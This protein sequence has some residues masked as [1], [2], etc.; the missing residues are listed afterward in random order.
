MTGKWIR[1]LLAAAFVAMPLTAGAQGYQTLD[2]IVAI[3]DEGVILRSELDQTMA[4]VVQQIS[5]RGDRLPPDSVLR[6]QV[7]ERLVMNRVQVQR[8]E[9]T[10]VRVSDQEVDQALTN[11]ANQNR[12]TLVQLRQAIEGDGMDFEEFREDVRQ[13]LLT[14]KLQQ[15]IV[16]SMDPVTDTEVDIL[17]AS[18]VLESEEYRL[19]QIALQVNPS[20]T[21][22]ELNE[23]RERIADIRRRIAEEGMD[24]AE[25]AVNFSE[26]ADA[27]EGGDV[28]WRNLNA[29]PRQV[30]DAIRDLQPGQ[31]TEP[32]LAGGSMVLLKVN[33]RRA[34]GEVIVD[35]F[36]ARHIMIEPSELLSPDRAQQLIADLHRRIREGEDFSE[37]AREY[38]DDEQSANLGGLMEWFP[39]GA[40]G[41]TFQQVCDALAPGE[42]SEPFQTGRGW[43]LVKLEDKRTSDITEEARRNEARNLIVEQRADEEIERMLRQFRDEAYVE[44]LI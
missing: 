10:G 19:A 26:S 44:I 15:R 18:G 24:F 37:L 34:R 35:E 22:S 33:D 7:L 32:L 9:A 29:L 1:S 27:L 36:S 14:Q 6:D 17:L 13:Q 5:A 16:E 31:V 42:L 30:A 25:A 2:E 43:H 39:E 23:V 12:L 41:Q 28:G 20:A 11:V 3:V 4:N 8:A 40:Y 38:S 21:P